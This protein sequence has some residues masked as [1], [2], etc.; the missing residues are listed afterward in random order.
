MKIRLVRTS[1]LRDG[2]TIQYMEESVKASIKTVKDV[3]NAKKYYIDGRFASHTRGELFDR[4]PKDEGAV[5][6]NK[7]DY[8]FIKH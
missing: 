5:Q 2:G 6:L 1:I 3:Q 4:Y 7:D 8:E